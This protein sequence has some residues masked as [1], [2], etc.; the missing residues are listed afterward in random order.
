MP[1][2][3]KGT[4]KKSHREETH[5]SRGES[6]IGQEPKTLET[7]SCNAMDEKRKKRKIFPWKLKAERK[8]QQE[9]ELLIRKY[10]KRDGREI[11]LLDELKGEKRGSVGRLK[12]IGESRTRKNSNMAWQMGARGAAF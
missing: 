5:E 3:Y 12:M 2:L 7:R 6:K 11:L 8:S 4:G 1:S 10:R 9:D